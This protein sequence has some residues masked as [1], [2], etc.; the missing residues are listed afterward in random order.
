MAL[1]QMSE[2]DGC[3]KRAPV[4]FVS[5]RH[6]NMSTRA[7]IHFLNEGTT[8]RR[9]LSI[10]TAT[11]TWMGKDILSFY[12]HWRT[13]YDYFVRWQQDGI[14]PKGTRTACMKRCAPM[15]AVR[16]DDIST[17]QPVAW[18]AKASRALMFPALAATMR[19]CGVTTV[20]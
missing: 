20:V 11:A 12:P 10:A 14:H 15:C 1:T 3:I 18:I 4:I 7:T 16:P 13:V 6:D 19:Y 17:L 2:K 9:P 5:G 8:S